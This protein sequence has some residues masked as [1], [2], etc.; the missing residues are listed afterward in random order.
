MTSASNRRP[1]LDDVA[2]LA[3]VSARSVSRVVN[4]EPRVSEH[5]RTT[6]LSAIDTLGYR[7]DRRAR[8]LASGHRSQLIGYVQANAANP[9]FAGVSRGLDDA[10]R[11][12]GHLVVSGSTDTDAEREHELIEALMEL[13]VDGLVIAGT[14]GDDEKVRREVEAGTQIVCVDRIAEGLEVDT[15]VS[16]NRAGVQLAVG[17]LW[18]QG[19]RSIA[20]LGGFTDLWIADE[21]LAGYTQA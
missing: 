7:P 20:F 21:R 17:H 8:M 3:D 11:A 12:T 19:H 10:V 1:T 2:R 14:V 18:D 6:V 4:D 9:F 16:D 13:R 15:V 5:L